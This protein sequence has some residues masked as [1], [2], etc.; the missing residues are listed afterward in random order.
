MIIEKD[1]KA[2]R[3]KKRLENAYKKIRLRNKQ[4][5]VSFIKWSQSNLK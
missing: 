4:K 1:I 5:G 3:I 2:A